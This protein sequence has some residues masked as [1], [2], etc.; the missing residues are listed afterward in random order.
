MGDA[1]STDRLKAG[2]VRS[3][4]MPR[5]WHQLLIADRTA[6]VLWQPCLPLPQIMI[7]IMIMITITTNMTITTIY[8]KHPILEMLLD[9][10]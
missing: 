7:L 5:R 1:E 8:N 10:K 4:S 2:N 6:P 9:L 3:G